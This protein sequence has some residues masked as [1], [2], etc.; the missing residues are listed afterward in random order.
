[1]EP[2]DI[3]KLFIPPPGFSSCLQPTNQILLGPR[4]S[5][6]SI[7]LRSLSYMRQRPNTIPGP[8]FYGVRV[9]IGRYQ[10]DHFKQTYTRTED[11]RP[12][13]AYLNWYLLS[14]ILE[15]LRRD[16]WCKAINLF[17]PA[18]YR[19]AFNRHDQLLAQNPYVTDANLERVYSLVNDVHAQF[20]KQV[21]ASDVEPGLLAHLA[22]IQDTISLLQ[23][24]G[25]LVSRV[26]GANIFGLLI[27]GLDHLG[28]LGRSLSPLF[29]KDEPFADRVVVK[30]ACR[31]LPRYLYSDAVGLEEGRDYFVVPVGYYDDDRHFETH[32]ES[33]MTNRLHVYGPQIQN[34]REI[35]PRSMEKSYSGFRNIAKFSAGNV[36]VFLE[37]C[38]F[39]LLREQ[40]IAG[41]SEV[42]SI[43]P[44]SQAHGVSLKAS[45]YFN[46]DLDYQIGD[47]AEYV[48]R[49][50]DALGNLLKENGSEGTLS[51]ALDLNRIPEVPDSPVN[52]TELIS[53]ACEFRYITVSRAN[54]VPVI[55]R[56][57][58]SLPMAFELS[59]TLAPRFGLKLTTGPAMRLD[60]EV[61]EKR[62][63][64][65]HGYAKQQGE[66]FE[67]DPYI[68]LSIAGDAW[69]KSVKGRVAA[70]CREFSQ[71]V[72]PGLRRSR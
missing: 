40:E 72:V 44:E 37:T 32:I 52:A 53:K 15:E 31:E 21:E 38:A 2:E 59:P 71:M 16:H 58:E 56:Q 10:F 14:I 20:C 7:A 19:Q 51:M 67:A 26:H 61:L 54:L 48:R 22:S 64:S 5:G 3:K 70:A 1:M 57:R 34:I 60:K 66:L 42:S 28:L 46:S 39:A 29:S 69:G 43:S 6:K 47:A 9:R 55:R 63:L 18:S 30:A 23:S 35:I 12:F 11:S 4:G 41:R 27:D 45:A 50:L 62:M 24:F 33:I 13:L 68:F 65:H 17:L 25:E 8:S 49:Y 36:L